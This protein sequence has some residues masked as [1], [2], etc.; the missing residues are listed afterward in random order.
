MDI[1]TKSISNFKKGVLGKRSQEN[2]L[3]ILCYHLAKVKNNSEHFNVPVCKYLELYTLCP[4]SFENIPIL[5]QGADLFFSNQND[6]RLPKM[7]S[8][9]SVTGSTL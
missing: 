1:F 3:D 8:K 6:L 7:G 5:F 2:S 4:E 9:Q